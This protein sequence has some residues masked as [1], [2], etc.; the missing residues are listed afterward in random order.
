MTTVTNTLVNE[1][2]APLPGITITIDLLDAN[3]SPLSVAFTG[4]TQIAA[5]VIEHTNVNGKWST[6]LF[7]NS[8]IIPVG[9][10][11]QVTQEVEGENLIS[12][13]VVPA[14]GPAR[15]LSELII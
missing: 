8:E 2:N 4:I 14:G 1:E 12:K 11:Y 9:T 3:F 15:H 10:V 7:P 13:F 6:D 5:K